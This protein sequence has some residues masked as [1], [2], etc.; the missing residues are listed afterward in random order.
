MRLS[1][2]VRKT[3]FGKAWS[4]QK[5]FDC[6]E[7]VISEV[8]FVSISPS[9]TVVSVTSNS[10]V[11]RMVVELK[12]SV[13]SSLWD[14]EENESSA[15]VLVLWVVV[16]MSS[17]DEESVVPLL[18]ESSQRQFSKSSTTPPML[19]DLLSLFFLNNSDSKLLLMSLKFSQA[20]M[21]PR[22]SADSELELEDDDDDEE[23]EDEDDDSL[24][25]EK[26]RTTLQTTFSIFFADFLLT[27][28]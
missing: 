23:D 13:V 25:W 26:S 1:M 19:P 11:G 27:S 28:F 8:E 14:S 15:V 16:V 9:K 21:K 17:S 2:T 3:D 20:R 6:V 12:S 7:L 24:R 22:C 18:L 4:V 5:M 10:V